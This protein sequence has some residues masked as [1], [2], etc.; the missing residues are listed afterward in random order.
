MLSF[1]GPHGGL[2]FQKRVQNYNIFSKYAKKEGKICIFQVFF[3]IL[4]A[5]MRYFL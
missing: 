3:S 4:L 2:L 1:W 5:D